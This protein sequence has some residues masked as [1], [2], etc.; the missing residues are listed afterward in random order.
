MRRVLPPR[1]LLA[2][3]LGL[4]TMAG[5]AVAR[6]APEPQPV[7]LYDET[8]R[9]TSSVVRERLELLCDRLERIGG[10]RR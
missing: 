4:A 10:E 6:R 1:A 9:P 5:A 3:F 2:V 8:P 7:L